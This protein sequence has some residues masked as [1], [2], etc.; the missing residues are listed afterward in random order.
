MSYNKKFPL[1]DIM[2]TT[3]RLLVIN[4]VS[5]A[6]NSLITPVTVLSLE[7]VHILV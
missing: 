2:S 3:V 4:N 1:R 7:K 6:R 5:G